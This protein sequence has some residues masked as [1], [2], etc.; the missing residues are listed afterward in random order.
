MPDKPRMHAF[1]DETYA[2]AGKH[3]ALSFYVV[4]IAVMPSNRLGETRQ[5][6]TGLIGGDYFH[7]TESLK[8]AIGRNL[9]LD[10]LLGLPEHV[11]LPFI[12]FQ[13]ILRGDREGEAT[14]AATL[15]LAVGLLRE[16]YR[17]EIE[18]VYEARRPGA[19]QQAD[20]RTAAGI[21]VQHEDVDLRPRSPADE[22]LL[23]IPDA[24]AAAIR[25][26]IIRGDERFMKPLERR[27]KISYFGDANG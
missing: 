20:L 22:P 4:A 6:L 11:D 12:I 7:A 15:R 18:I 13:P 21:K 26:K 9:L 19:Q 25:Q 5:N 2:I 24:A 14:R 1:I 23:W 10:L 16:S 27:A 17:G 8:S 3:S